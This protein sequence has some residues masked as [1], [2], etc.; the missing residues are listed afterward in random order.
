MANL[1]VT[2]QKVRV[3]KTEKAYAADAWY[4]E[5]DDYYE[6]D[7]DQEEDYNAASN[8]P[9]EDEAVPGYQ[10]ATGKSTRTTSYPSPKQLP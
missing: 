7:Q 6:E 1:Q 4:Y 5:E 3:S 2:A 10:K 9:F 8:Q